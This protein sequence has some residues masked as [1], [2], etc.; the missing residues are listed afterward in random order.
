MADRKEII[1]ELTIDEIIE[2]EKER[3]SKY[4]EMADNSKNDYNKQMY[5][6]HSK[7]HEHII[8]L[9]E[10]LK[11]YRENN[12]VADSQHVFEA[13]RRFGYFQAELDYHKQSSFYD[14]VEAPRR[15]GEI[16]L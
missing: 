4:R 8:M 7:E 15:A 13:W 9:L 1:M 5:I 11:M 12:G 6:N 3:A 2:N 10:E 16:N 14:F